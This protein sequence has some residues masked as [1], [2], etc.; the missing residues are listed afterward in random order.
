M[1]GYMYVCLGMYMYVSVYVY[2][3]TCIFVAFAAMHWT[4]L[5][6]IY[7]NIMLLVSC[8]KLSLNAHICTRCGDWE[9]SLHNLPSIGVV[10]IDWSLIY[11]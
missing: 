2:A 6:F 10:T 7:S 4:T 11:D 8:K 3:Y 1:Y 5:F 9:K